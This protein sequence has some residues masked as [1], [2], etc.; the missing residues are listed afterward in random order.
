MSKEISKELTAVLMMSGVV[1]WVEA[2][3]ATRL[4]AVLSSRDLPKF[5]EFEGELINTSSI[6][7]VYSAATMADLQRR[8]QG[9]WQCQKGR[10]H[11]RNEKCE[12]GR[13]RNAMVNGV[14]V[15]QEFV[16]GVGWC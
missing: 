7:G 4:R 3:R 1:M 8:K 6:E 10:W 15:R 14:E 12:C 16:P 9:Q 11:D 5:V 2:E 13:F